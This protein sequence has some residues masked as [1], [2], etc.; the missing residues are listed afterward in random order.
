M[1]ICCILLDQTIK[2]E[3]WANVDKGTQSYPLGRRPGFHPPVR[4][5]L[6]TPLLDSRSRHELLLPCVLSEEQEPSFSGP[7]SSQ[8]AHYIWIIV[9]C[10]CFLRGCLGVLECSR[11]WRVMFLQ[12]T[13]SS[14]EAFRAQTDTHIL[15]GGGGGQCGHHRIFCRVVRAV[16]STSNIPH[17]PSGVSAGCGLRAPGRC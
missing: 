5:F 8:I 14:S 9:I 10:L 16:C 3:S 11:R 7:G 17:I 1:C 4:A 6:N 12:L 2:S 15:L 13:R